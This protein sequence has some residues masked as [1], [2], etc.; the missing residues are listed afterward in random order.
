M[1]HILGYFEYIKAGYR[2]QILIMQIAG[3]FWG[4]FGAKV[5]CQNPICQVYHFICYEIYLYLYRGRPKFDSSKTDLYLKDPRTNDQTH[6]GL[7][8]GSLISQF[9]AL[10]CTFYKS[11]SQLGMPGPVSSVGQSV[12][13]ITRMSRVR[14]PY[15]PI[16]FLIIFI[17]IS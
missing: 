8:R 13:L 14:S 11:K 12:V 6:F 3:S 16:R 15:W 1:I 7:V 9:E 5:T 2:G 10:K 4:H 17:K